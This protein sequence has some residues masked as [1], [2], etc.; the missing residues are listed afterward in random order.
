MNEYGYDKVGYATGLGTASNIAVTQEP[1]QGLVDEFVYALN[2]LDQVV[3]DLAVRLGPVLS[4]GPPD[5]EVS[6]PMPAVSD[7][8]TQLYRIHHLT[9]CLRQLHTRVEV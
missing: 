4:P 9:G 6:D 7:A 3:N 5:Q 2:D 1:R 8:R